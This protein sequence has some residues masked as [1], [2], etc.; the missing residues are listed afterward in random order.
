[1]VFMNSFYYPSL[2]TSNKKLNLNIIAIKHN[3][4]ITNNR[5]LNILSCIICY[6]K[7]PFYSILLYMHLSDATITQ[8]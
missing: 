2:P 6:Y 4:N 8:G 7:Q 1:M 3:G 5:Y